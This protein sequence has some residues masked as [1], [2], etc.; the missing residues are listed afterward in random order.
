M[1]IQIV[2]YLIA[3]I[4]FLGILVYIPFASGEPSIL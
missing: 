2:F 1:L 3:G 4:Y